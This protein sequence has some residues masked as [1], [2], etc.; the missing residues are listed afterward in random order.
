MHFLVV[1]LYWCLCCCYCY[2]RSLITSRLQFSILNPMIKIKWKHFPITEKNRRELWN[3]L[4]WEKQGSWE[5]FYKT[6]LNRC[7]R[8]TWEFSQCV[9]QLE[10]RDLSFFWTCNLWRCCYFLFT[11]LQMH[12][13]IFLCIF[14]DCM[15][16]PFINNLSNCSCRLL[17]HICMFFFCRRSMH[18]ES[19]GYWSKSRIGGRRAWRMQ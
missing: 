19:L 6:C 4:G 14:P 11:S 8:R 7:M 16:F 3:W 10:T 2:F 5:L 17:R 13:P 12:F 15:H 9:E 1:S 18:S